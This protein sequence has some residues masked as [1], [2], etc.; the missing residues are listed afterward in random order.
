MLKEEEEEGQQTP[1]LVRAKAWADC[2]GGRSFGLEGVRTVHVRSADEASAGTPGQANPADDADRAGGPVA[3]GT[4]KDPGFGCPDRPGKTWGHAKAW[5][6]KASAGRR[7]GGSCG[8]GGAGQSWRSCRTAADCAKGFPERDGAARGQ[9]RCSLVT[10]T[11][12][13]RCCRNL[14]LDGRG[15]WSVDETDR[16]WDDALNR[17][18]S[19]R[20]SDLGWKAE[21][22]W[23]PHDRLC[24]HC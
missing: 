18:G 17:L 7:R 11:P 13:P 21:V 19:D 9:T 12:R 4:R 10:E 20:C 3:A 22:A 1:G 5:V 2:R 8:V 16:H 14:F 24:R 23:N 6:V 15:S